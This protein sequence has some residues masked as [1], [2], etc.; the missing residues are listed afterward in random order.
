MS[1]VGK[2]W[3]QDVV[4]AA[5]LPGRYLGFGAVAPLLLM[6]VPHFAERLGFGM[7]QLPKRVSSSLEGTNQAAAAAARPI[8]GPQPLAS[9]D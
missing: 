2:R 5:Q 8:S 3:L 1:S 9:A 7:G 4:V 6:P